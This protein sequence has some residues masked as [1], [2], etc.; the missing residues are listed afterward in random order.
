MIE[1]AGSERVVTSCF[2]IGSC[3]NLPLAT[4]VA[5]LGLVLCMDA[6][7]NAQQDPQLAREHY[8]AA[9]E[10]YEEGKVRE[11][12]AKLK[13]AHE[14]YASDKLLLS[15]ANRHLDLGEPEE[16]QEVLSRITADTAQLKTQV[17]RL[18]KQV[19]QDLQ[20]PVA[21]RLATDV[22]GATVSVDGGPPREAPLMLKLPRGM[23]HFRFAAAGHPER[24]VEVELR[25]SVEQLV[26]VSLTTPIGRWRLAVENA[27]S[28]ADVRISIGGEGVEIRDDER[29]RTVTDPREMEPGEHTVICLRGVDERVSTSV[30]V[31]LGQ[32]AVATCS[33]T[34]AGGGA[35]MSDRR[36]WAWATA[37]GALAAV[38]G[39]LGLYASYQAELAKYSQDRYV[40]RTNKPEFSIVLGLTGAGLAGL[41]AYLFVTED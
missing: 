39:S 12:L 31:V 25:G 23:H 34:S 3:V 11:S 15:I 6:P 19:S 1:P 22:A 38:A 41:S 13:A 37:G 5:A 10:L 36:T 17:Q 35:T 14:A 2:S 4:L 33:F 30:N 29:D 16:A 26:E 40:L 9:K 28:L 24:D 32:V 21:V 8:E 20:R 18:R 27:D 7:A